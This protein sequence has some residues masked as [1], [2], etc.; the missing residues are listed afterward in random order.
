MR[1]SE[2][3]PLNG[4]RVLDLSRLLPGPFLTLVLADLGA[5]V[6]KV[7]DLGAGDYL[8]Y[9]PPHVGELG[10]QFAALNRSKK[11]VL[12]DLKGPSGRD[13]LL[14]L[15]ETTDVVVENFR[16]G[17]MDRLGLGYEALRARNPGIVLCSVSGYG[18]DGPYRDVAGHDM[19]YIALAG[20][21]GISGP[22]GGAPELPGVQLADIAGG[23]LWG[24]V[25]VLSALCGRARS[26]RGRHV[27]ISMTEGA[28]AFLA[29]E[30]PPHLSGSPP[31]RRGEGRLNGGLAC[32]R[33]YETGDGK[34]LSVACLEPKFW[35]AFGKCIGRVC[36]P[37]EAMAPTA[38][39]EEISREIAA[40]LRGRTRAEWLEVFAG[41]DVC[42][43]PVLDAEDLVGHALHVARKL[44]FTI[45]VPLPGGAGTGKLPQIRTPVGRAE[46]H[47]PAP[48]P[49]Q[50][51][52]EV[53]RAAGYDDVQIAELVRAGATR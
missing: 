10:V 11:G 39:Q 14:K 49:G 22:R 7:E 19:N 44:F 23:A 34:Y 53:L 36:D 5:E 25:G 16:P 29:L 48:K 24:V 43:E 4:I 52:R 41:K 33:V 1:M 31:P 3:L 15:A 46:G 42:V 9:V 37:N 27:D 21:L 18:Q 17:V 26:G 6:I 8:R 35:V 45:D 20:V 28:A 38:R 40:L 2:E 51:T 30:L 50:H 13:A 47:T 12:L 32:Y